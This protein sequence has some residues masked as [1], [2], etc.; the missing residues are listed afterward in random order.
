MALTTGKVRCVQVLDD[1]GGTTIQV[2]ATTKETFILWSA[3][4]SEPPVRIRV[5]QSNWVSLLRQAIA[6]NLEV[7]IGHA[8]NSAI[9]TS[10]QLGPS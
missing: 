8:E 3:Q 10:V 6:S 2:N 4:S 1:L 9:A 7:T 5:M